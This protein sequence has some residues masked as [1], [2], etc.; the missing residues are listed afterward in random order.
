MEKIAAIPSENSGDILTESEKECLRS[1]LG[2]EEYKSNI[3][4]K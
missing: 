3:F 2:S 4:Y 1:I